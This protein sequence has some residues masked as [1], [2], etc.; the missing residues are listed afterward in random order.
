M[1][2]LSTAKVVA[3]LG[4]FVVLSGLALPQVVVAEDK[5]L[6]IVDIQRIAEEYEAARDAQEQYQTFIRD[7]E[8]EVAEKEQALTMLAEELESQKM[9]L[10]QDALQTKAQHFEA[11]KAEYFQFRENIDAR[12]EAE[13]KAKITPILDQVKTIVERIGKEKGFLQDWYNALIGK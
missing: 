12:A 5:P 9:L 2:K 3:V 6:G 11:Q 10:G 7:L 4:L 8:R 1:R 13:Y